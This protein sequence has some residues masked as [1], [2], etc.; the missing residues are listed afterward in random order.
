MPGAD[1]K[2]GYEP[3]IVV[4]LFLPNGVVYTFLSR[5][6]EIEDLDAFQEIT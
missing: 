1:E 6:V 2:D 4:E 5:D 3:L